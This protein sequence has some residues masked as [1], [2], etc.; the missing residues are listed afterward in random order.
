M[1]LTPKEEAMHLEVRALRELKPKDPE[2]M[3]IYAAALSMFFDRHAT[4]ILDI[5]D[6]HFKDKNK[7]N[8]NL[9][10]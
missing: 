10:G 6:K 8:N 2:S 4:E 9:K 1:P 7:P 5:L 3:Y